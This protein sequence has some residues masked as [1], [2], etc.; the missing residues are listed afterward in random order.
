MSPVDPA[1]RPVWTTG[2]VD[3]HHHDALNDLDAA[4]RDGL[5]ALIHKVTEGKDWTDPRAK[6]RL[7]AARARGVLCGAYHFASA[8]TNGATQAAFFLR[9][10]ASI[11]LDGMLLALDLEHNPGSAGTMSTAEAVA[12]CEAVHAATGRW[13]L[14]Y[15]GLSDL[16]NRV[17]TANAMQRATLSRCPLWLAAYGPDPAKITPPNVWPAYALHQYTNGGDGPHDA[18]AWPKRV[19]GIGGCDRSA[20]RGSV[21]EL[22]AWW[23][24]AGR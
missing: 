4:V 9:T 14:F 24:S 6:A 7:T 12:F 16:R 18:T 23:G 20:F 2:I 13:P 1:P 11:G 3:L 19:E 10:V 15:A 22:R 21:D 8:S 5:V 17:A